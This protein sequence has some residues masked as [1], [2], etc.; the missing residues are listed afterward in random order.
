MFQKYGAVNYTRL[1]MGFL[2]FNEKY[3]TEALRRLEGRT[4]DR[5]EV[6]EVKQLL[7]LLDDLLDEGYTLLNRAL[8][9]KYG[10]VSRLRAILKAHNAEPFPVQKRIF[11][12]MAYGDTEMDVEEVCRRLSKR[13]QRG[14]T[15]SDAPFLADLINYCRWIPQQP[16]TAYVFLLRDAFLPYLYFKGSGKSGL[17]PWVINR[18]FLWQIAGKD[19]DDLLRLPI[20]EALER[21]ISNYEDFFAFCK[22][23]IR[24]VINS[25]SPLERALRELSDQISEKKILVIESG[26]CGTIPLTLAA[27]DDRADFRLYTTAPFLYE[28]YQEKIFCRRYEQI[29]SFENLYAQDAL[30]KFSSFRNGRFYVRTAADDRIWAKAAKEAAV[31]SIRV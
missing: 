28:I 24:K 22:P 10:A 21:G 25:H 2:S 26:Y 31:L 4:L 15:P 8:E 13:T 12:N 29:R 18:D 20:Y 9:E 3:Y 11:S 7:K 16:D 30:M 27:L 6:Y 17:Y 19:T 5:G 23:R 1:G 14:I